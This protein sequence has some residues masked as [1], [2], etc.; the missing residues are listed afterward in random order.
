MPFD[1]A[2]FLEITK[3]VNKGRIE[4]PIETD[5]GRILKRLGYGRKWTIGSMQHPYPNGMHYC[6]VGAVRAEWPFNIFKR[7]AFLMRFERAVG[8]RPIQF[9]DSHQ[10][11]DIAKV[12]R[13]LQKEEIDAVR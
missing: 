13:K 12:L 4:P 5:A 3:V 2:G 11:S 1:N 6:L 7:K 8:M 9:N 10:W